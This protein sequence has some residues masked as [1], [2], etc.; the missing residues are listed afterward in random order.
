MRVAEER[1]G[2]AVWN[3]KTWLRVSRSQRDGPALECGQEIGE[4]EK[5][6]KSGKF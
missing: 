6:N 4:K 5:M 1:D 3:A 2:K